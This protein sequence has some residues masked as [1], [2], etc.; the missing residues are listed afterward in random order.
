[1]TSNGYSCVSL[2]LIRPCI[3]RSVLMSLALQNGI[4]NLP[5]QSTAPGGACFRCTVFSDVHHGDRNYNDFTCLSARKKLRRILEE[6]QDSDLLI[7]LG[8]FADYLKDGQITFYEEAAAVLAENHLRMY[9]PDSKDGAETERTI[10]SVIGNHEAAY[11]PKSALRDYLPY[12][13]GV[14]CVY[15][16][17]HED[18]LFISVDACFDR[19]TESDDPSVMITSVTFTIPVAVRRAVHDSV[20]A[21]MDG[22]VRGIVWLSHIAFKDID[23]DSR[24]AVAADLCR[25]GLPVTM[26]AGH[27]HYEINQ[28]LVAEDAPTHPRAEL[29]T[30]PA[31]TSGAHYRY[32]QVTFESG[33]VR[34]I[35]R[36]YDSVIAPE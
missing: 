17:R 9:R 4:V 20:E 36:R 28:Y 8:D 5:A 23:N 32:W 30:L 26:F 13:D 12:M 35:E 25:F 6:T 3:E 19:A 22:T 1:M 16:Y 34:E 24:M 27:T 18:V 14:G 10:L 21:A 29:Y 33:R 31:V 11:V 2:P 15:T 7:N